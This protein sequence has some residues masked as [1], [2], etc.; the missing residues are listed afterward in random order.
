MGTEVVRALDGASLT[1]D[2]G[3]FVSVVGP[4]GAGKSTLLHII[5]ALDTPTS[6]TIRVDGTDL[7]ALGDDEASEFRRRRVGFIFQFFNLVPTL[8]AWENVA[9]PMLLDSK[10]LRKARP[11]AEELLGRVGLGG[12]VNHRPSELS[13]GQMQRVAIA[14]SLMMGPKI[15]LA[16]EPTGNLDSRTGAEVLDLLA[17]VAHDEPD[18]L[19]LMVTHDENAAA[20][21]DRIVTVR[22]GRIDGRPA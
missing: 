16:D 6:G 3:Q 11:R 21:S 4:S 9:L 8:T 18:R 10:S 12:R 22:D 1:L 13:G 17:S 20:V 7:A 15:L 2:G 14:R 5:G 19:V